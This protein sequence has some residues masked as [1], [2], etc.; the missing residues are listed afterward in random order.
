MLTNLILSPM[1]QL[2][3][4]LFSEVVERH[5][6]DHVKQNPAGLRNTDVARLIGDPDPKQWT[7]YTILQ[8]MVKTGLLHKEGKRYF[9]A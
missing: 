9:L 8:R 7:S 4:P 5:I 3:H 2:Q 1:N 6:L